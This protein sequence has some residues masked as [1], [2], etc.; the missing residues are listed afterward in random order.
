MSIRSVNENVNENVNQNVDKDVNE[1][2]NQNVNRNV[3]E[4]IN[5]DV[6]TTC[7]KSLDDLV[8]YGFDVSHAIF[9]SHFSV[10]RI[11]LK[12]SK[13]DQIPTKKTTNSTNPANLLSTTNFTF[14]LRRQRSQLSILAFLL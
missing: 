11:V 10:T 1:N 2:A 4:N 9:P 5:R 7:S 6:I 12:S 14:L 13:P 8:H 3:S